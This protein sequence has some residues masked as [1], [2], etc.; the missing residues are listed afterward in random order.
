[1]SQVRRKDAERAEYT[2]SAAPFAVHT[3]T[4]FPSLSECHGVPVVRAIRIR[5]AT[6]EHQQNLRY[7]PRSSLTPNLYWN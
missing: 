5:P 3:S 1:M 2:L 4:I 7:K 6:P